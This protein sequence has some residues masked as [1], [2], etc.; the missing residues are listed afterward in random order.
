MYG[1]CSD[2]QALD[3]MWV[4][5]LGC[6][7]A[8]YRD[9]LLPHS[10]MAPLTVGLIHHLSYQITLLP[11]EWSKNKAM[12]C[13]E[14]EVKYLHLVS[15][16]TPPSPYTFYSSNI[17]SSQRL[18]VFPHI[19]THPTK[20]PTSSNPPPPFLTSHL[21]FAI[22]TIPPPLPALFPYTHTYIHPHLVLAHTFPS[23][24]TPLTKGIQHSCS[25][26]AWPL[27]GQRRSVICEGRG[28]C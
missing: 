1:N 16:Y 7:D 13:H 19:L 4:G 23:A 11:A 12:Y 25:H 6:I 9:L 8:V 21:L 17:L 2:S 5:R 15:T 10:S 20:P 22:A 18:L 3:A 28:H 27:E 24:E 14:F 26:V